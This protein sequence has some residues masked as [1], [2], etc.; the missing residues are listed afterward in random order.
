MASSTQS[1]ELLALCIHGGPLGSFLVP[2]RHPPRQQKVAAP[3]NPQPRKLE[4]VRKGIRF[5]DLTSP[6]PSGEPRAEAT[7]ARWRFRAGLGGEGQCSNP[8]LLGRYIRFTVSNQPSQLQE[9]PQPRKQTSPFPLCASARVLPIRS[10]SAF[11]YAPMGFSDKLKLR[12]EAR[13][14]GSG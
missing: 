10:R 1:V 5:P 14:P 11:S 12:A 7:E 8:C 9:S 3:S 4:P 13:P 2:M 6:F